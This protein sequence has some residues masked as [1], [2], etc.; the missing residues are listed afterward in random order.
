MEANFFMRKYLY[1]LAQNVE[2]KGLKIR[3]RSGDG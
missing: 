3:R 1:H 2:C